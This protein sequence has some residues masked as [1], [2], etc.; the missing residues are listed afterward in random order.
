LAQVTFGGWNEDGTR[1]IVFAVDFDYKAWRLFSFVAATGEMTLLDS[2]EDEAWVGGPCFLG[3]RAGA[4]GMPGCMGWIPKQDRIFYVSEETGWA[5][6]Y[7][8]APDGTGKTPLTSGT[9]EVHSIL[10]PEDRGHFILQTGEVSPFDRHLYR[11]DFDGSDRTRLF[12]GDGRF[13]GWPSPDGPDCG[14]PLPG[15]SPTGAVPGRQSRRRR[16]RPG[17]RVAHGRM[18]HLSLDPARDRTLHRS[19]E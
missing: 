14:G 15:E 8:I 2:H 3:P 19:R 12:D 5:H 7:G 11:M 16:A 10:I 1:G 9:W 6:L 18:A 13:E 17:D 4:G